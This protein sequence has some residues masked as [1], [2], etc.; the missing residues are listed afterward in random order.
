MH[1]EANLPQD[2]NYWP[3]AG[4]FR[5]LPCGAHVRWEQPMAETTDP[6]KTDTR[7]YEPFGPPLVQVYV[8]QVGRA[9]WLTKRQRSH[10]GSLLRNN[11]REQANRYIAGLC[12]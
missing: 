10:F 3:A 12:R 8:P 9:F 11:K 1:A 2:K 5:V 7:T 4:D 6:T